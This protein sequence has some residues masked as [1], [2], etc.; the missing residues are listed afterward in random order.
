[1]PVPQFNGTV[2]QGCALEEHVRL[3]GREQNPVETGRRKIAS[4][5]EHPELGTFLD[6]DDDLRRRHRRPA[7]DLIAVPP[8]DPSR[9]PLVPADPDPAVIRVEIPS[10]VVIGDPSPVGLLGIFHPVPSIGLGK[11]PVTDGIRPPILTAISR[12]PDVTEAPVVM[13]RAIRP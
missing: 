1:M 2:H 3:L 7:Y 6:L 11:D 8:V 5:H 4:I 12:R 10:P 9:A 13:P